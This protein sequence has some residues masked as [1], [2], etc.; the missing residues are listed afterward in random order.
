M[1]AVIA[2]LRHACGF[3]NTDS[4]S[5]KLRKL[6]LVFRAAGAAT[7]AGVKWVA[8]LLSIPNEAAEHV[9]TLSARTQ[10]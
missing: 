2:E 7:A 1:S 3:D 10:E 9:R 6:D 4:A 8:D 5:E